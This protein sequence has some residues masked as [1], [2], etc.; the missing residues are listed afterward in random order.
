MCQLYTNKASKSF[1]MINFYDNNF[2]G[3][4]WVT[5]H[6]YTLSI[7]Y[8]KLLNS[9]A[10]KAPQVS[11]RIIKF[12]NAYFGHVRTLSFFFFA[13]KAHEQII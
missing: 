9:V 10:K 13:V 2:S 1:A 7:N 4:L 8:A 5:M 6:I 3:N 11:Q 12:Y